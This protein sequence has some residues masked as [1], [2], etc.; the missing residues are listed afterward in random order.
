MVIFFQ[1]VSIVYFDDHWQQMSEMFEFSEV[2]LE[3]WLQFALQIYLM[4]F[5][6]A[7]IRLPS[8]SQMLSL[9]K[10]IFILVPV[11]LKA[12]MPE[13]IFTKDPQEMWIIA[14]KRMV[15]VTFLWLAMGITFFYTMQVCIFYWE[16]PLPIGILSSSVLIFG[17]FIIMSF[18]KSGYGRLKCYMVCLLFLQFGIL[19]TIFI[20]VPIFTQPSIT[21]KAFVIGH[22]DNSSY[23]ILSTLIVVIF[24]KAAKNIKNLECNIR[25][26][27]ENPDYMLLDDF[28]IISRVVNSIG[29]KSTSKLPNIYFCS[30]IMIALWTVCVRYLKSI[31]SG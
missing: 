22:T 11:T 12:I 6:Y 29:L 28:E 13:D 24:A 15:W 19:R 30:L 26:I 5:Y 1:A 8:P 10:S 25:F 16:Y 31:R 21:L 23:V 4:E 14:I 17:F 7:G 18:R 20:I 2:M 27:Q 9:V 3:T